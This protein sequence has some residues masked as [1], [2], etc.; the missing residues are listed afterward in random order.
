MRWI[1]RLS[2]AVLSLLAFS[3]TTALARIGGGEHFEIGRAHV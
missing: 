3:A 1:S 2:P